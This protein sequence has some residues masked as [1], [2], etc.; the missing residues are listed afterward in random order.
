MISF[1][2]GP[3][4]V[5][6]ALA[7]YLQDAFDQNILSISHRSKE[8]VAISQKVIT[9]LHEKLYIPK[10]Y[11]ILYT[12]SATECWEIIAQDI[13]TQSVHYYNG[14]FGKKWF[15][16]TKNINDAA[17]GYPFD[18]QNVLKVDTYPI[19]QSADLLAFTKN[20]TS[21]GTQLHDS[22]ID[23][24][25]K[26]HPQAL[27]ALDCTSCLGGIYIDTKKYDIVYGS[28][29]KCFGLPAGLG[30]MI[31]SPGAI[32]SAKRRKSIVRYNSIL[33]MA[34]KIKDYQ[35]TYTPNVL[36]IYLL[37]RV[38]EQMPPIA[39]T[40]RMIEQRAHDW[41]NYFENHNTFKPY[42]TNPEVRSHTV[43]TLSAA[44][45]HISAIKIKTNAEGYELGSGYGPLK[46]TTL[47]IANFP[48]I[49][50]QEISGLKNILNNR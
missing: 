15:E 21:T 17:S 45:E 50:D 46:D 44:K 13:S 4:K 19:T 18:A 27:T 16:Y 28:V 29:Q 26:M 37:S 48:A 6:P 34:E 41:Y 40:H 11:T 9:L 23:T 35:T 24:A 20:E 39:D 36:N 32:D 25:Y 3:S 47:R 1:N 22:V 43:I 38:L 2:V 10:D 12:S 5:N 14:E 49:A 31:L 42:I 33:S 8:F 7:Q 30:I